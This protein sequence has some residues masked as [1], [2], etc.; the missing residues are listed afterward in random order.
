MDIVDFSR[1]LSVILLFSAGGVVTLA[2]FLKAISKF[3]ASLL[4]SWIVV[5]FSFSVYVLATRT[6]QMI[7]G[8]G[9]DIEYA[10]SAFSRYLGATII[11][12]YL[13]L[14]I[15]LR[16]Q[17]TRQSLKGAIKALWMRMR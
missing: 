5:T 10:W 14:V 8:L 15:G 9:S 4:L 12:L 11:L 7:P 16:L 2:L 6:Y 17:Q 3:Q 1:W 13:Q